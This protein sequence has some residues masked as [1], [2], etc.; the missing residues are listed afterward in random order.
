[1]QVSL[2]K[3]LSRNGVKEVMNNGWYYGCEGFL[4]SFLSDSHTKDADSMSGYLCGWKVLFLWLFITEKRSCGLRPRWC[5]DV[6][7]L[8]LLDT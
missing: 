3:T 4:F 2:L 5:L 1:M 7:V 6:P 8:F